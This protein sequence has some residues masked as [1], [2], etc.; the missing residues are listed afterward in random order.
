MY[1]PRQ[2]IVYDTNKIGPQQTSSKRL[3]DPL[4]GGL[5]IWF[6]SIVV[7][8]IFRAH[9]YRY[10]QSASHHMPVKNWLECIP[11]ALNC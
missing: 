1:V 8:D 9:H 2:S 4:P 11:Q 5:V 7:I 6:L 10:T 3:I